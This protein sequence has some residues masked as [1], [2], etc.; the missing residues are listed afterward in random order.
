[1]AARN[2]TDPTSL[3]QEKE[4]IANQFL[5]LLN[6]VK[7]HPQIIRLPDNSFRELWLLDKA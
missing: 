1:M 3:F 4:K 2:N 7:I 6:I 5:S